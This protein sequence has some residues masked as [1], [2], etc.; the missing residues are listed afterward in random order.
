MASGSIQEVTIKNRRF[1]VSADADSNRKLGGFESEL[2]MNGDGTGQKKMT[3]VAFK[4]DG[5]QLDVLDIR[6]DH[7]FLQGI[8][9]SPELD[10]V[11]ITYVSGATWQGTGT[12]TGEVQYSSQNGTASVTLEGSAE[13]VI[14]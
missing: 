1:S 9:N 10:P 3:R 8:A 2:R 5:L 12:V 7:E 13:L 4:I 6:G 14:Q 11:T